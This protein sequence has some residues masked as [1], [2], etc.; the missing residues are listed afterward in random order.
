MAGK[1]AVRKPDERVRIDRVELES[2]RAQSAEL[3]KVVARLD[4]E[5]ELHLQ[6]RR[7]IR[8]LENPVRHPLEHVFQDALA[9]ARDGKGAERHALG[10][11]F[12]AQ[13]W[14]W[15][16][17][18]H[19]IGFLTGQAGK[20]LGEAPSLD[21]YQYDRELLGAIVYTAM[22][23]LYRREIVAKAPRLEPVAA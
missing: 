7:R 20:K 17:R 10:L 19:G 14:V 18:Q 2:L 13:P 21:G 12:M 5:Q 16:A 4:E 8:D 3:Q 23:V 1:K 11:P 22:A 9:Q 6:A 15:H